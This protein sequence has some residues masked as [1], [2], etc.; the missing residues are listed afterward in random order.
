MLNNLFTGLPSKVRGASDGRAWHRW[1]E[2]LAAALNL[3]Y[4]I[5]Y[6]HAA[7]WSFHLAALGSSLYLLICWQRRILAES[8]L[9]F[10]YIA[11]ALIGITAVEEAWPNPL[12]VASDLEHL[13]S[14]IIALGI[15]GAATLLLRKYSKAWRPGL[16][17]FTT[18]GS[19]LATY[20][21]LKFVHANWLYWIVVNAAAVILY[22]GRKMHWTV[23]LFI[24]YTALAIEGWFD[25]FQW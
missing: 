18:V 7:A 3:A 10:Y 1:G 2:P 20:W 13:I 21:M 22:S 23:G 24:L 9:W 17:A 8:F 6:M 5:G 16:D 19:L 15:W 12:P 11:M 4:T 25:F 14:I